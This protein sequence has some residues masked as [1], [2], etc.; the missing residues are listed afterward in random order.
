M[1]NNVLI[2]RLIKVITTDIPLESLAFKED[3]RTVATGTSDGR[4][5]IFDLRK[6]SKPVHIFN[7]DTGHA[8]TSLSFQAY[9]KV[10]YN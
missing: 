8:V 6:D 10:R 3:G 9:A 2:R 7:L 5:F 4:I 1:R